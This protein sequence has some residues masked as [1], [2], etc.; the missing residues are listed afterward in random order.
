MS[1]NWFKGSAFK[2]SEVIQQ[3]KQSEGQMTEK[4][5]Q[6]FSPVSIF[7]FFIDHLFSV[8]DQLITQNLEPRTLEP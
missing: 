2:G 4:R 6:K 7:D 8:I 1:I 5:G 3:K